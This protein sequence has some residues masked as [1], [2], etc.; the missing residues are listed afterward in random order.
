MKEYLSDWAGAA[1]ATV[2]VL[3]FIN[4]EACPLSLAYLS[5]GAAILAA[6]FVDFSLVGS[7]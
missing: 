6:D 2:F 5:V 1:F 4:F 3:L 7:Y